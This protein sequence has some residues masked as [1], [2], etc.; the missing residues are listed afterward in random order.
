MTSSSLM[1]AIINYSL[2]LFVTH[3]FCLLQIQSRA[4]FFYYFTLFCEILH[5]KPKMP[6]I[7]VILYLLTKHIIG[8][9]GN[10]TTKLSILFPSVK[11]IDTSF[12]DIWYRPDSLSH[13]KE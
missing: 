4:L 1:K 12:I 5:T 10:E 9:T 7:S 2:F 6:Y 13:P 3:V 11:S 8:S